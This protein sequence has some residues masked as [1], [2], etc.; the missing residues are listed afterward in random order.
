[1]AGT[2]QR[3]RPYRA[4]NTFD[5]TATCFGICIIKPA[6]SI[7][8]HSEGNTT[9]RSADSEISRASAVR[10]IVAQRP[11]HKQILCFMFNSALTCRSHY[12]RHLDHMRELRTHHKYA[13]VIILET[14]MPDRY[15]RPL[16]SRSPCWWSSRNCPYRYMIQSG[17]DEVFSR[18]AACTI[19]KKCE[20]T[21]DGRMFL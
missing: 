13:H 14:D 20:N 1:M 4:N 10:Q 12:F 19:L 21:T 9:P 17:H 5:R 11:L 15:E 8:Y 2:I 16:T 6:R 18:R 7:T 3:W